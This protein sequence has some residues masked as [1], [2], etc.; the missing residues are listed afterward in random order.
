MFKKEITIKESVAN[1]DGKAVLVPKETFTV[2][3][4]TLVDLD[5]TNGEHAEYVNRCVLAY[6]D[7]Q[8]RNWIKGGASSEAVAA[9]TLA[10]FLAVGGE[11]ESG[12]NSKE[13]QKAI[14]TFLAAIPNGDRMAKLLCPLITDR[15]ALFAASEAAVN[16]LEKVVELFIR[17]ED[18]IVVAALSGA[19]EGLVSRIEAARNQTED[20]IFGGLD[21][22]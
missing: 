5:T 11:R 19:I 15:Q 2:N 6:A 17:K 18:Q 1:A 8:V 22:L 4:P 20:D 16:N 9:K 12:G 21:S 7:K 14:K 13:L 3:L 10:D